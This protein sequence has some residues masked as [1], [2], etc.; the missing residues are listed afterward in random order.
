MWHS[1]AIAQLICTMQWASLRLYNKGLRN[2]KMETTSIHYALQFKNNK[3]EVL[4]DLDAQT[5][6]WVNA[7]E[8]S[9]ASSDAI[10]LEFAKCPHCT[11]SVVEHQFCPLAKNLIS[12]AEL[13]ADVVSTDPVYLEVTTEYR[14]ISRNTRTQEAV[15]G[16]MGIVMASSGC[17]HT[18]FFRPMVRYHLPLAEIDETVYRATAMY[19]LAQFFRRKNGKSS[20]DDLGG[21]ITIYE[22]IQIVNQAMAT[23]IKA[24]CKEDSSVNAVVILD[25][26]AQNISMLL[27]ESL[28]DIEHLF[29]PFLD[30]P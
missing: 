15:S 28:G 20:Q 5:L 7:V 29:Q 25:M 11:L 16:I 6:E 3:I 17:P 22:N 27:D 9:A 13:F 4:F 1:N 30:M 18:A 26:L 24:V 14:T 21:L 12:V 10:K 2:Y 19:M 23:R 8:C